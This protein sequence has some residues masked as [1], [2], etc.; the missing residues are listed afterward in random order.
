MIIE[1]AFPHVLAED[2]QS[3]LV[4]ANLIGEKSY[5]TD[6]TCISLITGEAEYLFMS[7][8]YLIFLTLA[9]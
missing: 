2:R 8:S 5:L 3:Y 7:V 9:P 4:F 1:N 6:S